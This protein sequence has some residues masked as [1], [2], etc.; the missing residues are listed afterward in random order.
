MSQHID[1]VLAILDRVRQQ[2]TA[3]QDTGRISDLRRDATKAVAKGTNRGLSG[4]HD[5]ITRRLHLDAR[6]IDHLI[7]IWRTDDSSRLQEH[8]LQH[9]HSR[10]DEHNINLFFET[11]LRR[12]TPPSR[13]RPPS[14]DLDDDVAQVFRNSRAVND[15]LRAVI[16]IAKLLGNSN[17]P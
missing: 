17:W 13:P 12:E 3:G 2:Y 16:T 15:T 5:A 7:E 10:S 9:A 8:L 6:A 14:I 1:D 4:I 11:S